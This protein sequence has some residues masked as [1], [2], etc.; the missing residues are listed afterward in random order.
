M[1]N[2]II[3]DYNLHNEELLDYTV[4]HEAI[5][6]C[7]NKENGILTVSRS[8]GFI[9]EQNEESDDNGNQTSPISY[10]FKNLKCVETKYFYKTETLLDN[11]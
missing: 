9:K 7:A 5:V 2:D 1:V 6:S 10:T 4:D 11:N 3:G 8:G